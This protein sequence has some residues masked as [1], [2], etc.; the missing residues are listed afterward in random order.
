MN[1]RWAKGGLLVPTPTPQPWARSHAALPVAVNV[2]G[3]G[4]ELHYSTR[5]AR[6]RAHIA[7]ATVHADGPGLRLGEHDPVPVLAPGP[8]GAFDDCGVTSSC[9]VEDGDRR[10]LFYTGWTLTRSVPFNFFIGLAVSEDA[11]R[12]Y[13]RA[14]RAPVLGRSDVDPYLTASPSVLRVGD[15][16]RMWYVSCERWEAAEGDAAEPRHYYHLR[17][18]ESADGLHW[19]P[20]GRVVVDF[21]DP[22]EYAIARP[23]V[24][25]EDGRYRMWFCAR[26]GA[27][28]LGY[29]ES[30]D[31]LRWRRDD[32]AVDLA[33]TPGAWDAEMVAYPHI[34]DV[35][36]HRHL[37]YNGN[38]YGRSGI[39]SAV[40]EA[41]P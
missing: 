3:D 13:A 17:Y 6:N 27:Y 37:L 1:E 33:P 2:S 15:T 9:V 22:S 29:A 28:R 19:R 21:S 10:L 11:G 25:Y 20:S 12:T 8:L 34:V 16:W 41:A 23:H 36:G 31:G 26:G 40:A 18:A 38:G 30:D 32:R 14:S 5:D 4:F 39:G 35:A 24:R 7:R